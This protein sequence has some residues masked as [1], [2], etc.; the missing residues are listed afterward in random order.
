MSS[1]PCQSASSA[2]PIACSARPNLSDSSAVDC[3]SSSLLVSVARPIAAS[4]SATS[5]KTWEECPF[6]FLIVSQPSGPCLPSRRRVSLPQASFYRVVAF[7][8]FCA[9]PAR[10]RGARP[11]T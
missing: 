1:K 7:A 4:S 6:T 2:S 9:S 5:L 8:L 3:G 11:C 10:S